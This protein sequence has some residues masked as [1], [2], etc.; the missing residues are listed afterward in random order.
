MK[1]THSGSVKTDRIQTP[2]EEMANSLSSAIGLLAVIA[3][4]PFLIN[5]ALERG[6]GWSLAGAIIFATTMVLLYLASTI[7]HAWPQNRLK[8]L[9]RLFDHSSIYLLIA[10]TYTPFALGA[11]RGPWGWTLFVVVWSLALLG[12]LFKIFGGFKYRK[13]S[14]WLYIALGWVGLFATRSFWL[15]VPTGGK[16]WILA[17]GLAYTVGIVFYVTKRLRYHHL[18]WHL[19]V[20]AGTVCHFLAVLWYAG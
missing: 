4:I 5:A 11:L 13:L 19:F 17:G 8:K 3:G 15:H 6:S 1:S 12:I 20:S 2:G 7:Y 18:I 14:T 10:G 16:L 9:F